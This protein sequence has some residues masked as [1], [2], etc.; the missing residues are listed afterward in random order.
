MAVGMVLKHHS[1]GQALNE[2]FGPAIRHERWMIAKKGCE[3]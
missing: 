2:E 3:P 1:P